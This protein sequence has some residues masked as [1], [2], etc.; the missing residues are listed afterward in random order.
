MKR[1]LLFAI[2]S[3]CLISI[4]YFLFRTIN[5][6]RIVPL[7]DLHWDR[8]AG[9][10]AINNE[11]RDNTSGTLLVRIQDGKGQFFNGTWSVAMSDY[12]STFVFQ[13]TPAG[14]STPH[15]IYYVDGGERITALTIEHSGGTIIDISENRARTYLSVGLRLGNIT[16]YCVLERVPSSGVLAKPQCMQLTI[17]KISRS[18]WN[19]SKEHELV[20]RTTGEELFVF[21]PWEKR[22][23]KISEKEQKDEYD[24]RV[25]LFSSDNLP[26]LYSKALPDKFFHIP[27]MI[28]VKGEKNFDAVSVP[29]DA[30]VGWIDQDHLLIKSKK[31]LRVLEHKTKKQA[32]LFSTVSFKGKTIL[33]HNQGVDRSW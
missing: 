27:G 28:I 14:T 13:D 21:D 19:P 30:F 1:N 22:P 5:D 26:S 9:V 3:V 8:V 20:L 25:R 31:S 15:T 32:K 18:V 11:V 6:P 7:S 24:A 23:R 4:A 17:S 2:G 10:V 16:S 33:F 29:F 12:G